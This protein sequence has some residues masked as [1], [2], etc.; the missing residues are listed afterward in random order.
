MIIVLVFIYIY[1]LCGYVVIAKTGFSEAKL[2][3]KLMNIS[4]PKK[5][6]IYIYIYIL[7]KKAQWWENVDVPKWIPTGM[8]GAYVMEAP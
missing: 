4:Y 1:I 2:M 3:I 6:K 7:S 8:E 5:K